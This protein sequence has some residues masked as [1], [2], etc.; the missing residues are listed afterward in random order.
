MP[1]K[2]NVT[3]TAAQPEATPAVAHTTVGGYRV[4]IDAF[5]PLDKK[6]LQKQANVTGRLAAVQSGSEDIS[7]VA[8]LLTQT[9]IKI[10]Y[11][12]HRVVV[13]EAPAGEPVTQEELDEAER[14]ANETEEG[15]T[16]TVR[17]GVTGD[18]VEDPEETNED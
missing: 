7:A 18:L 12:N 2:S 17:D 14:I 4:R 11:V 9:E 10:D 3:E 6:D 15:E 16:S 13:D 5:I 1:K 8:E